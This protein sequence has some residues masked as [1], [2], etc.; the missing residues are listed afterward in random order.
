MKKIP[1]LALAPELSYRLFY[2]QVPSILC[3]KKRSVA[4]MPAVSAVSVS[5]SPAR[6]G[7]SVNK[8]SN[9]RR[10]LRQA[11]SFSLS[12]IPYNKRSIVSKLSKSSSNNDKLRA[13][14][15]KYRM[16]MGAPVL[17]EACAYVI[18][19]K[20]KVIDVGDHDFFIGRVLGAMASLDF[21]EYWKF[22][23]YSPIL[24]LGSRHK[25]S[26]KTI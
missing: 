11:R 7:V 17:D 15:I 21:D 9:T 10:V 23:D 6:I 26:F 5:D 4:A 20:Q 16:I 19:E 3:V 22:K 2:P 8:A 14:G 12:W 18:L 24:Y 25:K 1:R 13:L